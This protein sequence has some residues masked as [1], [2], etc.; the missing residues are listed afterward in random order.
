MWKVL[1]TFMAL[2]CMTR[3][4]EDVPCKL[5]FYVRNVSDGGNMTADGSSIFA[6]DIIAVSKNVWNRYQHTNVTINGTE[7]VVRDYYTAKESADFTMFVDHPRNDK[8]SMCS[9]IPKRR[10]S[11]DDDKKNDSDP[12]PGD[13][14]N[15]SDPDDYSWS[16]KC[17][18]TFYTSSS[19]ENDGYNTAADGSPLK[20]SDHVAAVSTDMYYKLKHKK[21]RFNGQT[22]VVRDSCSSCHRGERLGVD[23]L[24]ANKREAE[25]GGVQHGT[26]EIRG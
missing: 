25:R 18:V 4:A 9:W 24:V 16:T 5:S 1:A 15:D 3:C 7:Y 22:Y 17:T 21:L 26:C 19:N 10:L 2:I 11:E 14:K 6:E 13:K 20:Y 12:D 23:I 8:M